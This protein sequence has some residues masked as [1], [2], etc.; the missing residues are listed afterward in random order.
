M[1]RVTLA[2]PL[3]STTGARNYGQADDARKESKIEGSGDGDVYPP[4]GGDIYIPS[5][6]AQRGKKEEEKKPSLD[7]VKT[8]ADQ[9]TVAERKELLAYL[10]SLQLDETGRGRDVDMWSQSIYDALTATIGTGGGGV[11]GPLAV[12]RLVAARSSWAYVETFM[13]AT[14]LDELT[15]AERQSVY[16]MLARLLVDRAAAV[17]K[18]A[19][20]PLTPKLVANNTGDLAAIFDEAFPGYAAAGLARFVAKRLTGPREP[21]EP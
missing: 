11:V 3:R 4:N 15:V 6:A 19:H 18:H 5:D 20:V 21:Q 16:T 14:K 2:R 17:A 8:L 10:A 12:K 9:L 13:A 1:K 7:H